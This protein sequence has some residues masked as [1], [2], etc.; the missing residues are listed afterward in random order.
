MPFPSPALP[1]GRAGITSV[2]SLTSR[3]SVTVRRSRRQVSERLVEIEGIIRADLLRPAM[4]LQ[5]E[6]HKQQDV[7]QPQPQKPD[8]EPEPAPG[9]ESNA[10]AE[11]PPPGPPEP[12]KEPERPQQQQQEPHRQPHQRV[13]RREQRPGPCDWPVGSWKLPPGYR[14]T[15]VATYLIIE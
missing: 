11:A 2:T 13:L 5:E 15:N 8:P 1:F 12:Q 3:T 14:Q 7:P 9:A 10:G 6:Q 4:L